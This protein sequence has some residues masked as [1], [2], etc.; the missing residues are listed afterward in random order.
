M[1]KLSSQS[2]LHSGKLG[3]IRLGIAEIRGK[4]TSRRY[5]N[6]L[7]PESGNLHRMLRPLRLISRSKNLKANGYK[8]FTTHRWHIFFSEYWHVDS[9]CGP[10]FCVHKTVDSADEVVVKT[11][12]A[13]I[14]ELRNL[15]VLWPLW[16]CWS[17]CG[18]WDFV[19][20]EVSIARSLVHCFSWSLAC[21][22]L[23][24]EFSKNIEPDFSNDSLQC[25][26]PIGHNHE[27]GL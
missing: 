23:S 27:K 24:Q 7:I 1:S 20:V 21:C 19:A 22:C 2:I 3:E 26:H 11:I 4:C 8:T 6:V 14:P 13:A 17:G 9:I 25:F 15:L 10:V 16:S 5:Y 18:F 12:L